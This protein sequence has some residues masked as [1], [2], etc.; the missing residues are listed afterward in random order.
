MEKILL[1]GR[2]LIIVMGIL[3]I[4][5]SILVSVLTFIRY[6]IEGMDY[7]AYTVLVS[8]IAKVVVLLI[9]LVVTYKGKKAGRIILAAWFFAS[10]MTGLLTSLSSLNIIL[11]TIAFCYIV[12]AFSLVVSKTINMFL[13]YQRGEIEVD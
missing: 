11:L 8:G 12:M 6:S 3:S 9:L 13:K 10:G 1:K 4:A 2:R 5:L 7:E